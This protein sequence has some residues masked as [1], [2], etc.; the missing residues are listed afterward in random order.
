MNFT[1]INSNSYTKAVSFK[2]QAKPTTALPVT[3][4]IKPSVSNKAPAL[5][6]TEKDFGKLLETLS[7]VVLKLR[8][9]KIGSGEGGLNLNSSVITPNINVANKVV[10]SLGADP[11]L[12]KEMMDN[13]LK[14]TSTLQP[15]VLAFVKNFR[16]AL[17]DNNTM[18][19]P[20]MT[21]SIANILK[22][23][24][25]LL[26]SPAS[27]GAYTNLAHQISALNN[28]KLSEAFTSDSSDNFGDANDLTDKITNLAK[29]LGIK[30][31][32]PT[33]L[34]R[35]KIKADP[36][37]SALLK[38]LNAAVKELK[39]S[40]G[41]N[42]GKIVQQSGKNHIPTKELSKQLAAAK[43]PNPLHPGLQNSNIIHVNADSKLTD[44]KGRMLT[45]HNASPMVNGA[46]TN[47]VI[48]TKYDANNPGDKGNSWLFKM[49]DSKTGKRIASPAYTQEVMSGR[50]Q[51]V[52]QN[53]S[54]GLEN[55]DSI[56]AN[57][58]ADF[59]DGAGVEDPVRTYAFLCEFLYW[60][61]MR[62]GT[63][64][65]GK[66]GDI[67]TQGAMSFQ[68]RSLKITGGAIKVTINIKG[69]KEFTYTINEADPHANREDKI[70][71]KQLVAFLTKKVQSKKSND[72]VFTVN[73][74]P[75]N[76]DYF[77]RYMLSK[78]FPKKF[79]AHKFRIMRGTELAKEVLKTATKEF[80]EAKKKV[81]GKELPNNAVNA[82][83][84]AAMTKV[85]Q[86]LGHNRGEKATPNTAI[87]YYVDPSLMVDW[88]NSVGYGPHIHTG[89]KDAARRAK[90]SV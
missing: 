11:K 90:I 43:Q 22:P 62:P 64:G 82:I 49:M 30:G 60:T 27:A 1:N 35:K 8:Q 50:K 58:R 46:K 21:S 78:E 3:K 19:S 71:I 63:H 59:K 26:G 86:M 12:Y 9:N 79:T 36:E 24:N 45:F 76:S 47:V 72:V 37:K 16:K 84:N 54:K 53:V 56:K 38:Q 39:F 61:A 15:L 20:M 10:A 34:Q 77:N 48:N 4:S 68:K 81:G 85:G 57:W 69:G 33:V 52:F 73:N 89:L 7:V 2:L 67:E 23:I 25:T 28:K 31:K 51:N 29:Q 6:V 70:A 44:S 41:N 88:Y 42:I 83:F 75:I 14:K 13:V 74:R 17:K 32:T 5:K 66:S 55:I 87:K 18:N 80:N 65:G 40:T